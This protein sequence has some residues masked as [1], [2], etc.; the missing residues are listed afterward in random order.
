VESAPESAAAPTGWDDAPAAAESAPESAAAPTGWDD[1]PAAAESAPESAAAPTA[2]DD[3]PAAAE[4]EPPSAPNEFDTQPVMLAGP[5]PWD[6]P[7]L[8]ADAD[9]SEAPA[10]ADLG[11][12][13]SQPGTYGLNG[14]PAREV[15]TGLAEDPAR[16]AWSEL[17]DPHAGGDEVSQ[18]GASQ[19]RTDSIA[20]DGGDAPATWGETAPVEVADAVPSEPA[21][22]AGW[23]PPSDAP[24]RAAVGHESAESAAYMIPGWIAP[25]PDPVPEGAGW[26]GEAL[27]NSAPLSDAEMET[28]RLAGIEPSDGAGALRLLAGLLR[29]LE[30]RG[31][32]DVSELASDVRAARVLSADQPEGQSDESASAPADADQPL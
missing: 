3:V 23:L 5:S 25:P 2:W 6:A 18:G 19:E 29:T 20:D 8:Q 12:P 15:A 17:V 24:G 1:A 27:A 11:E 26:L 14:A 9:P 21:A 22:A 16:N 10:A 31:I 13:A 4:A 28:L 7:G 32:L 30:R